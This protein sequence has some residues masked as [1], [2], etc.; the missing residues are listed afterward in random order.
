MEGEK[1]EG[2]NPVVAAGKGKW[3]KGKRREKKGKHCLV[4]NIDIYS[5]FRLIGSSR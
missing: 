2:K 4:K 1:K 5:G 3:G